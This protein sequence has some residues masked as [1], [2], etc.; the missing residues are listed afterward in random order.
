[1]CAHTTHTSAWYDA[2]YTERNKHLL[3]VL[4]CVRVY[5]VFEFLFAIGR[6][7][8]PSVECDTMRAVNAANRSDVGNLVSVV[9]LKAQFSG[10]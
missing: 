10:H 8:L 1:M 2:Y 4:V 3:G 6:G 9:F 5:D 7:E